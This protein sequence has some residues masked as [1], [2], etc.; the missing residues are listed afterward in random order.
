MTNS[1]LVACLTIHKI[2][3]YIRF[4]INCKAFI[5]R[6]CM[7][8]SQDVTKYINSHLPVTAIPHMHDNETAQEIAAKIG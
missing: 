7:K 1:K 3:S 5:I 8:I 6:K 4:A 2:E